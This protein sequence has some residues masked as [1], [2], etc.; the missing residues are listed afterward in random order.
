MKEM[1]YNFLNC[2]IP[3]ESEGASSM[4]QFT[5]IKGVVPVLSTPLNSSQK[6]DSKTLRREIEWV[7]KQGVETVATGMVSEILKMS[8]AERKELTEAICTY[9]REFK[10][11]S[12]VSCGQETPEQTIALVIHAQ[13]SGAT[14]VMVNPPI[15]S[16]LS[17]D[18]V[19]NYF[20]AVFNN[21]VIPIVVQDASGY[22]GYSIN[23]TVLA[24][25]FKEYSERIYFK[26]EAVPIGQRLSDLRDA[27]GGKARI[28]EGTGG[29]HLVDSFARGVIGTMPG[30]DLS[31][32][33]VKLWDS[34]LAGDWKRIN[35]INGAIANMVN[36]MPTLDAY[37]AIEKHLLK[38]QDVFENTFKIEPV[39]FTFD[40]ET[41]NEAER[42]FEYLEEIAR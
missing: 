20:A 23:V 25:L 7:G 35:L 26:P 5:E 33:M 36:L 31:W 11:N 30:A 41:Q 18:E 21:T 29:A 12:I 42:I 10:M 27:T 28:F 2:K 4:S 32:A 13:N 16:K 40:K 17:D 39:S 38:K 15:A 22:V 24:R 3:R 19:F 1:K 34:L 8:L 37:I 14:A 6:L 9:T